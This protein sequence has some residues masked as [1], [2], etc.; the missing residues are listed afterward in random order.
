M[1]DKKISYFYYPT[2]ILLLDDNQAFLSNLKLQL[3]D[4]AACIFCDDYR[5]ALQM[6]YHN[7]AISCPT[8]ISAVNDI[9]YCQA[10]RRLVAID[11]SG[12]YKQLYQQDRFFHISTVL[13][14]YSMPD[15]D[16]IEFCQSIPD[17]AIRR[18]MVT[19]VADYQ[20]AVNRGFNRNVI[21]QFIVKSPDMFQELQQIIDEEREK[22]FLTISKNMF[23]NATQE[24][25]MLLNNQFFIELFYSVYEKVSA[26]EYYLLDQQ[27]SYIFLDMD[28]RATI[29]LMMSD[30]ELNAYRCIA[31]DSGA[32]KSVMKALNEK[33]SI[34]FLF[35]E[36]SKNVS[37]KEWRK[38]LFPATKLEVGNGYYYSVIQDDKVKQFIEGDQ[39][40]S[41]KSF[42][43]SL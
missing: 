1:K 41:Y 35:T 19:G 8:Y 36:E 39:I 23:G 27:G 26:C 22:Y 11:T 28:G 13:I 10:V 20:I 9:E 40:V 42:L 18:I 33:T 6:L 37:P 34:P 3:P 12:I 15:M 29:L 2:Y 14:D 17:P 5:E 21:N 25:D 7:R 30:A 24:L 31:K 38:Y 43:Q 4:Q 16:G 32:L